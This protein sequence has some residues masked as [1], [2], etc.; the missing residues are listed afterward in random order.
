MKCVLCILNY[1][2]YHDELL[3]QSTRCQKN[4][5][6]KKD[7]CEINHV[8]GIYTFLY[9]TYVLTYFSSLSMIKQVGKHNSQIYRQQIDIL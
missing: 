8:W 5:A 2:T 1:L 6:T 9:V 4:T 7:N 3:I